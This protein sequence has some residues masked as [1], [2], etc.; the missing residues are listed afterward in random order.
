ME[1]GVSQ[2]MD[3]IDGEEGARRGWL[4]WLGIGTGTLGLVLVGLWTQ[5]APIV[6]NFLNREINRRGVLARYRLVDVGLRTQRI[7]K[8]VLGDPANPDLTADWVEVDIGFTGLTPEVAAVRAGGV[9]MRGALHK[10]VLALGEL[11]KFRDSRSTAPFSLPDIAIALSDARMRLSTDVG[12]I[13]LTLSGSGNLKSGFQGDLVAAT[14]QVRFAGCAATVATAILDV[15]I[16]AERPRFTG[17]IKAQALGCRDRGI[18]L[19]QPAGQLNIALGKALDRWTGRVALASAA[20]K[21]PGIVAARPRAT[22][23]FDGTTQKTTGRL[24]LDAQAFGGAGVIVQDVGV[25]ARWSVAQGRALAVEANGTLAASSLNGR[26]RDPLM[27]LRA[28]TAGTPVGPLAARLADAVRAAGRD[29][30]LRASFVAIQHGADGSLILTDAALSARSGARI[31]L[32]PNSRVALSWP[33]ARNRPIDWALDGS[34]T[35]DGGELP[36]AAL[37]LARRPG[38]GFGGQMFIDPYAA[39]G[40]RLALEAIRFTAGAG[41]ETRFATS[42]RLDGP[43]EGGALRGLAVPIEGQLGSDG[44]LTVNS[45]CVPVSL[46]SVRYGGFSLGQTRQIICPAEGG[47]LLAYTHNGLRGGALVRNVVLNGRSG[48]SPMRISADSARMTLGQTGF[49]LAN[50]LF[51]IGP[52]DAPV[53]MAAATLAGHAVG[54]GL[55]GRLDGAAGRISTVPLDISEAQGDWTFARGILNVKGSLSV[56]D[57]A[58]PARFNTLA[59]RD[60][61]LTLRNGRITANGTLVAPRGAVKVAAVDIRHDL[62][63]GQG[64]A[65]LTVPGVTFDSNLQPEELT[66]LAKGVVANVAGLITGSGQIRWTGNSVTSDGRFRTD[67][68]NLAAAFGP[69]EGLSGEIKFTDLIG[70]VTAPGQEVHLKTVNPGVAVRDGVVR[71]RLGTGQ[72]VHVEGGEWPFS[73][74]RLVLLPTTL[75]FGAAVDRYLTFRVIGMDAGAFIQ[76]MELENISATGTFDGIMPLIFDTTGGRIAGGVLVARQQG[77]PPLVMPEGV[78]PTIPCDPARQ[79]GTLSYVGPVSNEQLGVMGKLAFDALKNLQYKCLTILMDGALD[80]E[81]VTNVVFN[82]VNRGQIGT[83]PASIARNF[84]GLPFLFNV[85]VTAPFR[86]LLGTAQSF[87]DPSQLIRNSLADAY[88]DKLAKEKIQAQSLKD[89]VVVQPAESDK[90]PSREQK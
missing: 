84:V 10:G 51:S 88:A 18:A 44:S 46:Q 39:G 48:N 14:P 37:R 29:N 45:R 25:D 59:S 8:L 73:G 54:N 13:G 66:N 89:R 41:G 50:A 68:M 16:Q 74:G 28:S 42:L 71:Y 75:D 22:V 55:A 83:A 35:A 34:I 23:D 47:A 57:T 9:R 15:S 26:G 5:R 63:N 27:N 58:A 33:G 7:E 64:Q 17:P 40:A 38:G 90:R 4:R 19:A 72:K 30:Q 69:V 49:A 60:F 53:R 65:D 86:G 61:A 12:I 32:A 6:D 82:G 80:G 81:M 87:I 76:T 20:L 1:A 85:R 56:S 43:L 2:R 31:G 11:D 77:M 36:R 3:E 52:Q 24:Y 78:L 62:G 70:L 67:S 79:S 21:A